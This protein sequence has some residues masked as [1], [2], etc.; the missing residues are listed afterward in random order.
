MREYAAMLTGVTTALIACYCLIE[1]TQME[2]FHMMFLAGMIGFFA[3]VIFVFVTEPHKPKA[4]HWEHEDG[5][6]VMVMQTRR[7]NGRK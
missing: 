3:V 7:R 1:F 5:L 4:A 6:D 2:L